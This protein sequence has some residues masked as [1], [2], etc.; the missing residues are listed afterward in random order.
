MDDNS[1]TGNPVEGLAGSVLEY[2][3]MR[4]DQAKLKGV[5]GLS[6]FFSRFAAVSLVL[7]LVTVTAQ[8]IGLA[9]GYRLGEMLGSTALGF[10]I[11]GAFF[12]LLAIILYLLRKRL[13]VNSFVMF[14]VKL[15][16]EEK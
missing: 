11:T 2:I 16:F 14:F 13:F 6:V 9:I 8:F 10:A 3:S 15:F 1:K 5:E 12:L 7:L 4:F